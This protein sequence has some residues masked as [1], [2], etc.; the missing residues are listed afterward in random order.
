MQRIE[1]SPGTSAK[2]ASLSP[3]Q[4]SHPSAP[5]ETHAAP[6]TLIM[7]VTAQYTLQLVFGWKVVFCWN[8]VFCWE[9]AYR[10]LLLLPVEITSN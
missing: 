2:G 8:M 1:G 9:V 4:G 5:V 6:T 3:A 7:K 10:K